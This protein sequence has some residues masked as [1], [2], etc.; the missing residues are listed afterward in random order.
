MLNLDR[1]LLSYYRHA[2]ASHLDFEKVLQSIP[3]D[4]KI[5]VN[6]TI[7]CGSIDLMFNDVIVYWSMNSLDL[8]NVYNREYII[9]ILKNKCCELHGK[10]YIVHKNVTSYS[11]GYGLKFMQEYDCVSQYKKFYESRYERDLNYLK[12]IA[13][14][15]PENCYY[16]LATK[17]LSRL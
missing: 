12:S 7:N 11:Y 17:I 10:S 4:T 14:E 3:M 6:M 15:G 9:T 1:E 16:D 8:R 5:Y 13:N 2:K